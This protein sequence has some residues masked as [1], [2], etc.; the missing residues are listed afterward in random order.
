MRLSKKFIVCCCLLFS[1]SVGLFFTSATQNT[2]EPVNEMLGDYPGSSMDAGSIK[3]PSVRDFRRPWYEVS[4][5]QNLIWKITHWGYTY[6]YKVYSEFVMMAEGGPVPLWDYYQIV[7]DVVTGEPRCILRAKTRTSDGAYMQAL[8]D[9]EGRVLADWSTEYIYRECVGDYIIRQGVESF[10][11]WTPGD[12]S[13]GYYTALFDYK[14]STDYINGVFKL[15]KLGTDKVLLSG[16]NGPLYVADRYGGIL[17]R[18]PAGIPD[19]LYPTGIG[20]E[21]SHKWYDY[22]FSPVG[23]DYTENV[24]SR[25]SINAYTYAVDTSNATVFYLED[26]T[27]LYMGSLSHEY[28]YFD[29]ELHI[30]GDEMY[31]MK[32]G[33]RELILGGLDKLKSTYSEGRC[34]YFIGNKGADI[35]VFDR[36]GEA[37]AYVKDAGTLSGF[38]SYSIERGRRWVSGVWEA[39]AL[40]YGAYKYIT[41]DGMVG[42]LGHDLSLIIEPGIYSDVYIFHRDFD[43]M[44]VSTGFYLV[45]EKRVNGTML[46]DLYD[47][48]GRQIGADF[49]HIYDIGPNRITGFKGMDIGMLDFNGK[50]LA[51]E[52]YFNHFSND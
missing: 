32:G 17:S 46:Y 21:S 51:K 49:K 5:N 14:R 10:Y 1:L 4:P 37:L 30:D 38:G 19:D 7:C 16:I 23:F 44:G 24:V 18:A 9:L 42:V 25:K 15:R 43:W 20:M 31:K 29:D 2:E 6:T 34:Q 12:L 45:A 40:V 48:R 11:I 26:G 52:S 8:F 3:K 35:Y 28:H 39:G 41:P 27:L 13:K 47:I 50:W 22:R 33:G 36:K